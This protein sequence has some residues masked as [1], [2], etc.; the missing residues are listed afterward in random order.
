MLIL[1]V[2]A[3]AQ[4]DRDY[5]RKGN[6]MMRDS[7]FVEA[8]KYYLKAVERNSN[9]VEAVYNLGNAYFKTGQT[10]RAI[11]NY[12]R[13]LR[14]DPSDADIRY[15]LEFARAQTQD[16]IDEVPE[17]ILKTWTRKMGYWMSSDAWAVLSLVLLAVALGLVLLFMLGPTAGM[18][19]TGFFAGIAALLLALASWGFARSQKAD[20]ERHD[21]AIVMRPVSSVTS[22]PSS[23]AAKSLFILH[24]GTKVKV[25][26]EVS[27]YKDIELSDGRRG[28][29]AAGDIEII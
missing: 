22:S 19:R 13:A 11:L 24:E 3:M 12:E 4:T 16:R 10:A 20:A 23:D 26:D 5:I 15:N 25:L 18:R 29:I 1:P 17:F 27:G 9:N 8:E 21:E 6:R 7:N 28:W 14:L 2:C